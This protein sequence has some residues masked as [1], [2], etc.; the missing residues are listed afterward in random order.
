LEKKHRI[1]SIK[2]DKQV[3]DIEH[4]N[5][6]QNFFKN[7]F[8]KSSSNQDKNPISSSLPEQETAMKMDLNPHRDDIIV[9]HDEKS[10]T[11]FEIFEALMKSSD[12]SMTEISR[13][14]RKRYLSSL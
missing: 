14:N 11:K 7:F 5:R 9:L 8:G 4:L 3:K 10:I 1:E 2:N 12:M 13:A 6:Q